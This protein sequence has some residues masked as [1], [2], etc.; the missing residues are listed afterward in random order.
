MPRK[1]FVFDL[2]GV[3]WQGDA[4]I[5]GAAEALTALRQRGVHLIFCTN[6]STLHRRDVAAKL[7]RLVLPVEVGDVF[8][9]GSLAARLLAEREGSPPTLVVG[10]AGF[11][12][13]LVEAGVPITE[14]PNEARWL[15]LGL[16]R[17]VDF[18]RLRQAHRALVRGAGF[19]AANPDTLLPETDGGSCPGAGALTALLERSSGRVAECHGK[20][21]PALLEEIAR[22]HGWR[23]EDM[24]AVGD[25]L[26]TD[27]LAARRFG[28]LAVLVLTGVC[29]RAEAEAASDDERPD[30]VREALA[31][32][33]VDLIGA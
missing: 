1:G 23:R 33:L 9:S 15:A 10:E 12:A 2:D 6:N 28:C 11:R 7:T 20:P 22:A 19:L 31:E 26:D 30:I 14:D 4:P 29:T 16:D 3:V 17:T 13:E 24:V 21:S 5:T 8:T 32:G 27:V 18:A 25:R